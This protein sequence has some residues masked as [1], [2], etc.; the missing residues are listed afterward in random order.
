MNERIRQ[1]YIHGLEN[2]ISHAEKGMIKV[3]VNAAKELME[4]L[5]EQPE[6]VHCGDCEYSEY[7]YRDKVRCFLWHESGIDVFE[8]GYCNYGKKRKEKAEDCIRKQK[9]HYCYNCKYWENQLASPSWLPCMDM[10]TDSDWVCE[11][12][13]GNKD[14]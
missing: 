14:E 9:V 4:Y 7:W 3:S 12:W 8:D 1:H 13:K 11:K 5:K 2:A 10:A 6:I